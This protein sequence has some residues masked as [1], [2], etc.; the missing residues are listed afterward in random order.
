MKRARPTPGIGRP[1]RSFD[2]IARVYRVLEYA[3]FG[4]AL[5]RTRERYLSEMDD[6]RQV[7]AL[8]DGDGRFL[9]AL[10]TRNQRVRAVAID[11]S[12]RM[13][14]LLAARCSAARDRLVI[15]QGD[16]RRDAPALLAATATEAP[17]DVVVS[18]FF[19]DCLTEAE[20]R[21]LVQA[22]R[23]RLS[24]AARWILSEFR[25]PPRGLMRPVSRALIRSLYFFFWL[26]TGLAVRQMP[27]Y[28]RLLEEAG[29]RREARELQLL[30]LLTSE[31][32][33]RT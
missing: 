32:W 2:R 20:L 9:A 10:M 23:P 16:L 26:V 22:V 8:G 18:H 25:A 7:L 30:G 31:I 28:A 27:D 5:Q 19:L 21:A 14:E 15:Q 4:R 6:A 13:L 17:I 24:P 1:L 3:S 11:A 29:F 12:E 33:R